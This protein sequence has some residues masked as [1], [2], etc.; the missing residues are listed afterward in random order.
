MRNLVTLTGD[1]AGEDRNHRENAGRQRQ[2]EA[3]KKKEGEIDPETGIFQGRG[4]RAAAVAAGSACRRWRA[5]RIGQL[6]GQRLALRRIA[7]TGIGAALGGQLELQRQRAGSGALDRQTDRHV[8]VIDLDLAEILVIVFLA[9]GKVRGAERDRLALDDK[10]ELVAIQ[11]I[12][13]GNGVAD[14]DGLRIK[15]LQRGLE[16]D[17]RVEKLFAVGQRNEQGEE[18]KQGTQ[19][20]DWTVSAATQFR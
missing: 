15:R 13:L 12:A 16:G 3:G 20:H 6:D 18:N 9:L 2:A 4:D 14:L 8:L 11:V 1:D 5:R 7:D 17:R 10:P 19:H